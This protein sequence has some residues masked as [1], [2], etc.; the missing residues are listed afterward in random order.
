MHAPLCGVLSRHD[1][2]FISTNIKINLYCYSC[3]IDSHRLQSL[4]QAF[5]KYVILIFCLAS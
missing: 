4:F 2:S 3:L 1:I 5:Y